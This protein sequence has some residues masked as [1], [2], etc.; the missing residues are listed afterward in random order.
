ML[1]VLKRDGSLEHTKHVLKLIGKKIFTLLRS[2]IL[3]IYTCVSPSLL[4]EAGEDLDQNLN[5]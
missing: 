3:F 1:W 4:A 2:K 5:L